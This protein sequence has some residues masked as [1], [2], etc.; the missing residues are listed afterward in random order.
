MHSSS[1]FCFFSLIFC[2]SNAIRA[3][4]PKKW[5]CVYFG[6]LKICTLDVDASNKDTVYEAKKTNV[7]IWI[8]NKPFNY[9]TT[10]FTLMYNQVA[11]LFVA[12]RARSWSRIFG[13]CNGGTGTGFSKSPLDLDDDDGILL[14][15]EPASNHCLN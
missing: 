3:Q 15:G 7:H 11:N 5:A 1:S 2:S 12:F 9:G 13:M 14:A 8:Y 10:C 6:N 4:I